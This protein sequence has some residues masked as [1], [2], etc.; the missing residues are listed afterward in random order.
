VRKLSAGMETLAAVP[1]ADAEILARAGL[2]RA[3]SPEMVEGLAEGATHRRLVRND[4]LF[5][6]D[7]PAKELYVVIEGRIAIGK[8]GPD[9]RRSVV[10][11]LERGDL[12]GEMPLFDER[13]RSLDALALE[14]T[15]LLAVPYPPIRTLLQDSPELLWEVISLL[16]RWIRNA[17]EAL[18]DSVFLDVTGRT[19]KRL[20]ELSRDSDEFSL[21]LTQEQLAGLVGAS[22]ERVNKTLA[23]FIRLGW[24][25]QEHGHYRILDR[26]S[27]SRRAI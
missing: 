22:R 9:G 19:A 24:L 10:G 16:T 5:S 21:P 2:F 26:E 23:T 6:E 3:M 13:G 8:R 27:L 17:D 7:D 20:L 14:S 15:E 18:A 25:A 11:V 4:V 1:T 12:F